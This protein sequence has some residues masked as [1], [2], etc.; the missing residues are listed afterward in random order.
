[1]FLATT[2]SLPSMS[3]RLI[4]VCGRQMERLQPDSSVLT[5]LQSKCHNPPLGHWISKYLHVSNNLGAFDLLWH[6]LCGVVLLAGAQIYFTMLRSFL[7]PIF[8]SE[9]YSENQCHTE[10]CCIHS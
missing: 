6:Q 1:M 7:K 10:G 9:G 5:L 3:P 4:K 8:P 2:E